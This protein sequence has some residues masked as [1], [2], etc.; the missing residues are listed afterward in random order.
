MASRRKFIKQATTSAAALSIMPYSNPLYGEPT[1]TLQIS[2]A[3]WS[4]NR[5][6]RA[7]DIKS[8]EF[9]AITRNIYGLDAVEFVASFYRDQKKNGA[10]WHEMLQRSRDSGVKNLLI[11]VDE[12]GDLGNPDDR[13]RGKAVENHYGWVDAAKATGCHSIRVNA[14][15]TGERSDVKSALVDGMSRLCEYGAQADINILIE[16][17]GLYSSEADFMVEVIREVNSPFM[18][19]LPDFGNWCTT[20]K[21]GATRDDSCAHAYDLI[22]GVKAFMPFAKGVSAKSYD[23]D[24][25]G[26]QARIDYRGLLSVVKQA[27]YQGYIGIEYEGENLTEPDGIHATK[28]LIEQVWAT[29]D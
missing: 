27:G 2:L 22:E 8:E 23:F 6:I 10:F 14:F 18:G 12:E 26:G 1:Q 7:G 5:A 25:S 3:Q 9:A 20:Q 13:A 11:M 21:W 19:T 29:L 28:A 4:L 15:G 24:A 17:H 16:N